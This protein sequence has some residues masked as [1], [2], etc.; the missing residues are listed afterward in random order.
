MTYRKIRAIISGGGTGGHIFPALSIAD[1]LKEL[2]GELAK[3]RFEKVTGGAQTRVSRLRVC[4]K[5][6][7]RLMTVMN[8][9]RTAQLRKYY[10]Q[11]KYLPKQLRVKGTKKE[12]RQLTAAQK[13]KLTTA[14]AKKAQ[15]FPM[16][17]F[18]VLA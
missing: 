5:E 11:A 3:L 16:R 8:T 9:E 15:H 7:A 13:N 6:I 17:K 18:Y 10:A 14:A 1:K 2:K 12:R 4:K